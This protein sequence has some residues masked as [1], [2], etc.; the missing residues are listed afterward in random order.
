GKANAVEF[1]S[2]PVELGCRKP[3]RLGPLR[4]IVVGHEYRITGDQKSVFLIAEVNIVNCGVGSHALL[5]P[6][7][8][9]VIRTTQK[10]IVAPDPASFAVQEKYCIKIPGRSGNL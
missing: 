5:D 8:A 9:P 4:S 7:A 1:Y 3:T 2:R 6:S 10:T